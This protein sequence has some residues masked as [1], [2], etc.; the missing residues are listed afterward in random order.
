M[1]EITSTAPRDGGVRNKD[2]VRVFMDDPGFF[3]VGVAAFHPGVRQAA[4]GMFTTADLRKL[5]HAIDQVLGDA[6]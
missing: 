2:K 1:P 5:R 3:Y 6:P 4:C